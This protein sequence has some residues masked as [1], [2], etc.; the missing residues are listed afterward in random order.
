MRR[1]L[2]TRTLS[3]IFAIWLA[4]ALGDAGFAHP[5]CPM[6]DGPVPSA[7]SGSSGHQGGHAAHGDHG[8]PE[9]GSHHLCTCIGACS[10]SSGAIAPAEPTELPTAVIA[11]V[12]RATPDRGEILAPASRPPF[13]LPFANGPPHRIA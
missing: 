8:A 10:A 1:P 9:P 6:H 13:T 4:L 3:A 12:S 2:W 7:A 11:F 5:H